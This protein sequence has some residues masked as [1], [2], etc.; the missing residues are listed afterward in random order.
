MSGS[1]ACS[2]SSISSNGSNLLMKMER[3]EA[4]YGADNFADSVAP[5]HAC[6]TASAE[7]AC[8]D[9]DS[10]MLSPAKSSTNLTM[11]TR[12]VPERGQ[13]PSAS[14]EGFQ[15]D[16]ST[17]PASFSPLLSRQD[18]YTHGGDQ[19]GGAMDVQA[20]RQSNQPNTS[21]N[22]I[23]HFPPQ[24][25]LHPQQQQEQ[26]QHFLT[27]SLQSLTRRFTHRPLSAQGPATQHPA[28]P[29]NQQVNTDPSKCR[30]KRRESDRE[31]L[32][33]EKSKKL[34]VLLEP[35][36]RESQQQ[37]R[38]MTHA[39]L[40]NSSDPLISEGHLIGD[41]EDGCNHQQPDND[42]VV[43]V[44]CAA[45]RALYEKVATSSLSLE[46]SAVFALNRTTPQSMEGC[47]DPVNKLKSNQVYICPI[48]W[49]NRREAE[50]VIVADCAHSFCYYCMQEWIQKS[51]KCPV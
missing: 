31:K 8:L 6:E 50:L 28:N 12:T 45:S 11:G 34:L 14:A 46:D 47:S 15:H 44:G 27:R 32:L 42:V 4:A 20:T 22:S 23:V 24:L 43:V 41:G 18:T 2:S 37:E 48:C 38:I 26:Q 9:T 33:E 16:P 10:N 7:A 13:S 39:P 40:M 36:E 49:E 17:S 5:C 29:P 19:Q 21:R 35:F 30:P 51:S 25:Q 3:G 1:P